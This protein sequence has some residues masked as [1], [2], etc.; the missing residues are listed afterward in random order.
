MD[1]WK[2]NS[3][4][5]KRDHFQ[6]AS[7]PYQAIHS[8]LEAK[9]IIDSKEIRI[10]K[11]C[12]IKGDYSILEQRTK[13]RLIAKSCSSMRS[14]VATDNDFNLW[15][16]QNLKS[17]PVLFQELVEG[18]DY[19]IHILDDSTWTLA[20]TSKDHTDYRYSSKVALEYQMQEPPKTVLNFCKTLLK[21]EQNRFI[22]IDLIKTNNEFVCLESNPGPGWSTFNHPSRRE[23]SKSF[24]TTLGI[25]LKD[26]YA[27]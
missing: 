3:I 11:T 21:V 16:K 2:G 23:F 27:Q 5:Q 17:I 19:R 20:I 7:K 8:I 18:I 24:N 9:R 10:P 13:G 22:G 26:H 14:I 12:L 25:E 6:N 1:I 4:G 15:D